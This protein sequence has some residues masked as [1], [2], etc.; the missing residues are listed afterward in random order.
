VQ[1]SGHHGQP[2]RKPDDPP[3][4]AGQRADHESVR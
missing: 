1:D 3:I 4:A 2:G